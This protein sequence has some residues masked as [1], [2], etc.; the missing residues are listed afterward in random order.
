M[1]L[2]SHLMSEMMQTADHLIVIGQ[3]RILADGPMHEVVAN[4]TRSA[5]RARTPQV[6]EL[7]SAV[8]TAEIT[9]TSLPDGAIEIVGASAERVATQAAAAGV[10][11]HELTTVAGSLEDAYLALTAHDTEYRAASADPMPKGA[12]R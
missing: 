11:L 10:V 6:A 12:G 3:G 5:V 9:V 1:L 7:I 4:A 2:S 8:A